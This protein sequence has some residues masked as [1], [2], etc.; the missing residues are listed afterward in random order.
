M[1]KDKAS[2]DK[3]AARI[4]GK[5]YTMDEAIKITKSC[6]KTIRKELNSG[7]LK[8]I[9]FSGKWLIDKKSLHKRLGLPE[10]NS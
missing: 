3:E 6:D 10:E 1:V 8:G 7:A 4:S 9:K 2:R 5:L